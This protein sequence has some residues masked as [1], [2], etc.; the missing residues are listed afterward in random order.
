MI[1]GITGKSCSGKNYISQYLTRKGFEVWDL[2]RVAEKIRKEKRSEVLSVFGT[3][4]KKEIA[5]IVFSDSSKLKELEN[6]IYPELIKKIKTFKYDLAINGATIKRA[7]LDELCSF[8]I[9]VDASYE[10]RLKRAIERDKITEAEFAKREAAQS[11]TDFRTNDYK[12]KVFYLNTET[13]CT[14]Q[15]NAIFTQMTQNSY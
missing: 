10:T 13:D 1:I 8:I 9:Y 3:V 5:K 14:A 2:D 4:D 15:L 6:I 11:D 12:C 7:G